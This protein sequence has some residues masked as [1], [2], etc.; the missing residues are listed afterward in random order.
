MQ[1]HPPQHLLQHPPQDLLLQPPQP[2]PLEPPLLLPQHTS[3]APSAPNGPLRAPS[4]T[5][6]CTYQVV[7]DVFVTHPLASF[8]VAAAAL[9][10]GAFTEAKD[11]IKRDKRGRTGTGRFV[12]LS[13]ET[14]AR[15]GPPAFALL[16]E[17][18]DS[19]G[20]TEVVSNTVFMETA[21]ENATFIQR[22]VKAGPRL[23]TGASPPG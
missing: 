10:T 22:C 12:P 15:A 3:T 4:E 8:A 20:W 16:H 9:S 23:G 17:L 18:A 6:S 19:A 21:M 7:V 11:A 2:L 14:H 1:Q 13:H 5:S